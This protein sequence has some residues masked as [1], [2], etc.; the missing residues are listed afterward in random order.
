MMEFTNR[1]ASSVIN[2]FYTGDYGGEDR[3]NPGLSLDSHDVFR[4]SLVVEISD[5]EMEIPVI[6]R[7]HFEGIISG[8]LKST[9]LGIKRILLPLYNNSLDQD[10]RTFDTILRQFFVLTSYGN[11]LQKVVTNKGEIYYGG[12]G[13]IFDESFS[14]LLL[15]T[16]AAKR[17]HETEGDYM[18]YHRPIC[19]VSPKVFIEDNKLVNKNIIKKLI[20]CYTSREV[21]FP[22][23]SR[24]KHVSYNSKVKVVVDNFDRFFVEPVKPTPSTCSDDLLNKCIVDNIEDV[25]TLI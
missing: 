7:Q 11:R 4:R 17:T 19:H 12:K 24:F 23:D 1:F 16:L 14:P 3:L 5:N 6:A 8:E 18:I 2:I 22:P 13:I 25:L 20:P 10:R 21:S 15:C 9:A